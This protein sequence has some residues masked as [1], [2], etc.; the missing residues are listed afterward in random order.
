[1]EDEAMAG[2]P[3]EQAKAP[4]M[5][6]MRPLT[7]VE[8][9]QLRET[10]RK[11]DPFHDR[12]PPPAPAETPEPPPLDPEGP[13]MKLVI[14]AG[15]NPGDPSEQVLVPLSAEEIAERQEETAAADIEITAAITRAALDAVEAEYQRRIG[16][17][18]AFGRAMFQIDEAS[19]ARITS[20]ALQVAL[21]QTGVLVDDGFAPIIWISMA[22]ARVEMSPRDFLAFA[23]AAASRVTALRMAARAIK[24]AIW[25]APDPAAID[26]EKGWPA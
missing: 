13:P 24:D 11:A 2:E 10:I 23:S 26:I 15:E 9:E 21:H 12:P 6:K 14:R 18:V 17:G 25:A 20:V 3:A 8:L 4:E 5:P 19:Q 22:D 16:E 1:M 7:E